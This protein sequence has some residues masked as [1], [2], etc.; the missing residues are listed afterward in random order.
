MPTTSPHVSI[1][2]T[3]YERPR[4]LDCVLAGLCRQDFTGKFEVI[5][6]DDGSRDETPE[7]VKRIAKE[8]PFPIR[9]L[10]HE[11][12]GFQPGYCRNVG[13]AATQAEYVLFL[14]GDCVPPPWFVRKHLERRR[15]GNVFSAPAYRLSEATSAK[16]DREAVLALR[17]LSMIP[18]DADRR[19][20]WHHLKQVWYYRL[21]H[22]TKPRVLGG[23]IGVW[24]DDFAAVN[25]FDESFQG[26][27]GEDD[28]FGARLR[29]IGVRPR[30]IAGDAVAAHLW[31]PRVQSAPKKVSQGQ[32]ID[33]LKRRGR[34]ACCRNG[35]R[36]R[37]NDELNVVVTGE[38]D[39]YPTVVALL[40][41]SGLVYARAA[42]PSSNERRVEIE[43]LLFPTRRRF[44][45]CAVDCRVLAVCEPG[46]QVP[47]RLLRRA[48]VVCRPNATRRTAPDGQEHWPLEAL[49]QAID[50]IG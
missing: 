23:N 45:A 22:P 39:A 30:S 48:D 21:G 31:H 16:I 7:L 44:A 10:T 19:M 14:D 34:L 40:R 4:H 18:S 41:E 17:D 12:N 27:G 8:V 28:D 24:R 49:P 2:V 9:F 11:H 38:L 13:F 46:V 43:V 5:V 37:R 42:D 20:R 25:G 32:N 3:T 1:V 6:S 36:K 47:G 33:Y 29:R 26:W 35:L 15:G 50:A